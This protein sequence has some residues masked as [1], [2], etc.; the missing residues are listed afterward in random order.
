M[1]NDA[2]EDS[3]RRFDG[4][5]R[6][7]GSFLGVPPASVPLFRPDVVEG[8]N[9]KMW[10]ASPMRYAKFCKCLRAI[11]VVAGIQTEIASFM[12]MKSLRRVLPTAGDFMGMDD[13]DAQAIGNS[14]D[15]P[16]GGQPRGAAAGMRNINRLAV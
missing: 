15:V 12:T 1:A 3:D 11:L 5:C 16:S 6:Y 10:I 9:G 2:Y 13:R 7:H 8:P 14:V 4:L